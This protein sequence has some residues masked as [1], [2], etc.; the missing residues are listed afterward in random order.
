MEIRV[1]ITFNPL[2]VSETEKTYTDRKEMARAERGNHAYCA[3]FFTE[4]K[5]NWNIGE[6]S[7]REKGKSW[8]EL[9]QEAGNVDVAVQKDYMTVMSHTMS[10]EDYA[11]LSE[12]GFHFEA[13]DPEQAVTIVDKIKAELA[14]SG[15]QI[16]GYTDDLN[17]DTLAAAL[18]SDGLARTIAE[19]FSQADIPM[20]QENI[21]GVVK[22]WNMASQL[23]TPGE[24]AGYYMIDNELEPE[25]WN[26]YLAQ[27]SGASSGT[28]GVPRYFAEDIR[29]YF[30]QSA[31]GNMD[32]SLQ[33]QI[34]RVITDAGLE[35]TE[36]SRQQAQWLMQKGLPLTEDNLRRLDELQSISF[37]VTEETFARAAATAI[38]EGNAPTHANLAQRENLY[39]KAVRLAETYVSDRSAFLEEG[40]IAARRQLEEIRLRMTAEVNVKLLKSGFSIDTAPMEQLVEALKQ[41]ESK[42]ADTY[43]PGDEEAVGKYRLYYQTTQVAEELPQM[44]LQLV[45]IWSNRA[46]EGSIRTFHQ[47]GTA[48]QQACQKAGESYEALMT[49]PRSDLG[50]SIRKAFSNVDEIL[51]DMGYEVT[52]ENQRAVRIL[53]YNRMNITEENLEAVKATDRQIRTVVE[54]M[55]PAAVLKMIRDGVNP[56]ESSFEDLNQYIDSLPEEYEENAESYSRFLYQLEQRRSIS[57]EERKEYIHVFRLLHQIEKSDGAVIG[58]LVNTGME[59]EFKNLLTAVKSR[60]FKHMDVRMS[61]GEIVDRQYT[62]MLLEQTRQVAFADT[63]SMALLQRGEL[64]ANA[65]NLLAARALLHDVTSS[66]QRWQEKLQKLSENSKT[67]IPKTGEKQEEI[68]ASD[69]ESG[70]DES[71]EASGLREMADLWERL[72]DT[73]AFRSAYNELLT[74]LSSRVES[75][76]FRLAESSLDVREMQMI[77]KQL[78]VAAALAGSEEYIL[79]M[80]IGE[81]LAKVHLTLEHAKNRKSQVNISVD[82]SQGMHV[83]AHF[84]LQEN[85]LQGFLVG[86]TR[87]EVTKLQKAA[88]IFLE[89]MEQEGNTDWEISDIPVV[90]VGAGFRTIG[91]STNRSEAD[92]ERNVEPGQ[93]SGATG[94]ATNAELY[95]VAKLFLKAV[96]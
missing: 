37:P 51:S 17:L 18:G 15:Q 61:D 34:D 21:E 45:G 67:E 8:I 19:S 92:A 44:P 74:D 11:A 14:R 46:E 4:S 91:N 73:V 66:Y 84:S 50:D 27:S 95:R 79:P 78:S 88:D 76:T 29:G 7:G 96:S 36:E 60:R 48:L 23:E 64:P 86:N 6:V 31:E 43:F 82:I 83:E 2:S 54:K 69:A 87:E 38:A 33:E 70:I 94:Q 58:T 35:M 47:E 40:D 41:A 1:K 81:D 93:A 20:T 62:R 68:G 10:E 80:Y 28:G 13:L 26:L 89:L 59:A 53:G 57:P 63:D 56:L 16:V 75:A 30:A 12:D 49:T 22:A 3:G 39:E 25:I 9:Q 52:E 90:G 5:D 72:P 71:T 24:G 32:E 85:R 77:H 55:T 42:L 65:G